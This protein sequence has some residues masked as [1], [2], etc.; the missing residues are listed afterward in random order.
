MA[1]ERSNDLLYTLGL[2]VPKERVA[3]LILISVQLFTLLFLVE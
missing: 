2:A 3:L 1:A